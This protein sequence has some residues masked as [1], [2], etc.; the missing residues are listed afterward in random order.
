MLV[1]EKNHELGGATQSK[2]IFEGLEA[3]LSIYSYLLSLLPQFIIDDLGLQLELIP[4]QTASYSAQFQSDTWRELLLLNNDPNQN[5]QAFKRL[6]GS[7]SEYEG[8][9]Q[10][11]GMQEQIASVI[12]PSL[13]EPLVSRDEMI[14]RLDSKGREAWQALIEEPL[15]ELIER[16]L[17][18][19]LVRGLLF[20]D[21]KIG[22][23]THPNDSSL[24]QNRCFLYHIIGRGT[25]EW[26]VPKGGMGKLVNELIRVCS[27]TG[28]VTFATRT[29]VK[30]IE[31]AKNRLSILFDQDGNE[32]YAEARFGLCSAS[33]MELEQL[34]GKSDESLEVDEGTA[35]KVNMLLK[36][37]PRLRSGTCSS[38]AAFAGTFHFNEGYSQMLDSYH[39]SVRGIMPV[40]PP[41][42]T[43]CHSLSDPSI[44]S[45]ELQS[46]GFHTLTLFGLD[47]P[48]RLFE[49]DNENARSIAL[50]R[51]LASLNQYLEDPIE[52]CLAIDAN[53]QLCI[54]AMSAVDLLEKIHLPKGNIFHGDL[55]W[56]F[57]E[58]NEEVGQWGVETDFP[59]LYLCGSSAKRGGAVSG[60]PGYN[61]ARKVLQSV[62][63]TSL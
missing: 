42:E 36:R 39:D 2:Q 44:L 21:A 43:Y 20:T 15:G 4:R 30:S 3:R 49:Q 32:D 29:E 34:I 62:T 33:R 57:A 22:V 40:I 45:D 31:R 18:S 56:P 38:E 7:Q 55:S 58:T 47:M 35:F 14:N 37:L 23:S 46:Q 27:E 61:A 24:L 10:I 12:W 9:L 16:K 59:N 5:Q 41:G 11:Q 51:Y 60:I 25:G 52:D 54:E 8:Y 19:D 28:N 50:E 48:Y 1:L 6:L 17:S 26:R 63:S 13:T 53:G